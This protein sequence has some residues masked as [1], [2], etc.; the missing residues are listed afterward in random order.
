MFF[1]GSAAHNKL[2]VSPTHSERTYATNLKI[3]CLVYY[4]CIGF[5]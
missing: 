5:A 2:A 3:Y 1:A 4:M